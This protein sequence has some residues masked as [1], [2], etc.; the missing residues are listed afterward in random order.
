MPTL[1]QHQSSATTK[2]LLIGDSGSGKSGALASLADAG[3][4]L[5]VLDL[6]NGLDVLKNLLTDPKSSYKQDSASRVE[7]LTLTDKMRN[8]NGRLVPASA[9]VWSRTV[10]MLDN[11]KYDW[12][13]DKSGQVQVIWDAKDKA[14]IPEGTKIETTNLGP[15]S[16]WT[17]QDVLVIDSFTMLANGALAFILAMNGRLG[18]QPHQSDWYQGQV[19][20]EGLL[21]KLYDDGIRCSI[22]VNCHIVY[23]GEEGGMPRGYPNSLGKALSPKIGRYFNSALMTQSTG[24]GA[25]VKRKIFTSTRGL[26]ELKNT[27]PLKVLPEYPLETGLADYFKAVR[28]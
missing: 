13:L 21:Q 14:A 12:Y 1:S 20:L 3:F 24:S 18:Q 25:N 5:R 28:G 6:D 9:S 23:I 26:V 7:Y 17:P 19:L 22:I 4:N 15:V 11:W 8:I 2:M 16:S 10:G 27:A